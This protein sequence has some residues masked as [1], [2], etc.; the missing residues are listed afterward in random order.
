MCHIPD[1][2]NYLSKRVMFKNKEA[3][4]NY[5]YVCYFY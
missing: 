4:F 2:G 1:N 5:V 3:I